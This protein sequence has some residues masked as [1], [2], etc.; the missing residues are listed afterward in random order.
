M[1]GGA[2]QLLAAKLGVATG[3]HLAEHCRFAPHPNDHQ[4]G[5]QS[6]GS[7]MCTLRRAVVVS[8]YSLVL[9][10][11]ALHCNAPIL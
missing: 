6:L 1:Q 2:L 9:P 10:L 3:Q 7:S 11:L 4:A 5:G 8:V